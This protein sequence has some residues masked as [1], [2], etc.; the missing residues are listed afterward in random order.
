MVVIKN[1]FDD[2]PLNIIFDASHG[3]LTV[4]VNIEQVGLK[5]GPDKVIQRYETLSYASLN[6]I[7]ELRN[8]LN[9]VIAEVV[10]L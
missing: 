10:G 8:E 5:T 2:K 7:I 6:E 1:G 3:D 9:K 4:G